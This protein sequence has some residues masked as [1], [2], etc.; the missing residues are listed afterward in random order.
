MKLAS[1]NDKTRDGRL[2]VVSRDNTRYAEVASGP[3]TLQMLLDH[4]EVMSPKL[5]ELFDQLNSLKI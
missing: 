3:T 1:F 2:V 5:S 4:W